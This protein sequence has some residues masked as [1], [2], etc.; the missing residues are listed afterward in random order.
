MDHERSV[1]NALVLIVDD[2][3]V[4]RVILDGI[5]S[6]M[7]YSTMLA[8]DGAQALE[9]IREK[10][11]NLVLTDIS[12]PEMDGYE[13]CRVLK[14]NVETRDIPI[15]FISAFDETKD[16]V[17]GFGLG[18]GDYITKP[19]IPELIRARVNVHLKLYEATLQAREAN[20]RLQVSVKE[21]LKQMEQERKDMLYA[22]AGVAAEYSSH[23][24]DYIERMRHNCRVL[25]QSMQISPLFDDLISDSFVDIVELAAP[26]CDIGNI[27]V[28]K[29][30]LQKKG[31]LDQEE[32]EIMRNHTKIGAKLLKDLNVTNEFMQ[33]SMDIAHFH[34]ENWDGSGYPEGKKEDE[35]PLAAQIVA[36][37][38]IFCAL[39]EDRSFRNKYSREEALEIMKQEQEQK[40]N[41]DVFNIFCKV[42]RQLR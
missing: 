34:H 28:P 24:E 30:I 4:N 11:P 25:A 21:Q 13:L 10:H 37:S 9:R 1:E 41:P 42:A 20:R 32:Q 22:L 17:K 36:M 39:T 18:G 38:S 3:E 40:F 14:A 19:F 15:I 23:G 7:G 6:D 16:I 33:I 29:D 2:V 35:I 27:G 5:V 12:M 31:A 26:L 8:A